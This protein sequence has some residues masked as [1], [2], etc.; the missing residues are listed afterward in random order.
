MKN[1]GVYLPGFLLIFLLV[2]QGVSV[3]SS[4]ALTDTIQVRVFEATCLAGVELR[5]GRL[6]QADS[7]PF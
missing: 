5:H 1:P 4:Y 3:L 6:F 2:K 7:L